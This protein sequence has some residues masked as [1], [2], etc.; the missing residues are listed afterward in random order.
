MLLVL[1]ACIPILRRPVP[2]PEL[3][4]SFKGETSPDNSAQVGVDEFYNDPIL[5]CL[6]NQAISPVG[7]RELKILNEEVQVARNEILA[8]SGQYLPFVTSGANTSLNRLSHY[9]QEGTGLA[10]DPYAPG[11]FYP[12]PFGNYGLG[13]NLFWQLDIYR[14]L[15]NARDAAA[16][17]YVVASERR[18]YFVTRLVADI[19]ENYYALMALDKRLENLNQIIE[20]QEQS[21]KI[22]IAR[23][24]AAR[25][26]E[27]PVLRFQA[28]VR[29]NYSEK[30]IVNQDIIQVENRINFLVNR[31]PQPVERISAGF[32]DLK[33]HDLSMGVPSELL[34]NRA[35]IRQAERELVA[36]GLDVKVARVNFYPQ[37][38]ITGG[39]GFQSLLI[40]HLFEPQA[41]LGNIAGGLLGP[42]FNFRAIKAQ[43]LTA[44]A[45]QLQAIYN[46]QRVILEAFTQVVNRLTMVQNYTNSIEIKKQQLQSLESAV[47]VAG[48]LFQNARVEY[49]DVLLAQRDLRDARVVLI[50]TKREQLSAIVNAYQAIGGGVPPALLA[51]TAVIVP[52]LP[53]LSGPPSP[54]G[55]PPPH[56]PGPAPAPLVVPA[57]P[58]PPM[59]PL[60]PEPVNPPAREKPATD[61]EPLPART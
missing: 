52:P 18:N 9:T 21:L 56:G 60:P 4:E 29:R 8:R 12:N 7:N 22:A 33:L 36:A 57:E 5:L 40:D 3:P 32:F 49:L 46:Y 30:L 59:P 61:L 10:D 58:L 17:R 37:L 48:K 53:H 1:P 44:N 47:D 19:A 23:K 13:V 54:A 27:L 2:A 28:E 42:V 25:G 43:Y 50:D 38:V 14:Q 6:L 26:T 20:F 15:R 11:R 41:V 24:E 39:V 31:Y 35:D 16:Q 55:P 51:E 45:R 34:R